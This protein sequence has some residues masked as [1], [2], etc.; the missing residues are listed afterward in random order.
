MTV[1]EKTPYD[2]D[3][4][5][6]AAMA[7]PSVPKV[8]MQPAKPVEIDAA[9]LRRITAG[10]GAMFSIAMLLIT[11]ATVAKA[12]TLSVHGEWA[13]F[14]TAEQGGVVCY[15]GSEPKKAEGDYNKRG[16]TYVLVTH[17][18]S[19]KENDV[20]SVRAGYSY[21]PE[22]QVTVQIGDN[23]ISLFTKDGH[24]W[25][26]DAKSDSELVRA[27]KRGSTMVIRGTSS[28]GTLTTDTYSL[29]G[30][31]AAYNDSRKACGL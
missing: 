10:F 20:V 15:I 3:A 8:T 14:K 2:P 31:T 25:A 18:P 9:Y 13:A 24:A 4:A 5:V 12:E 16:D 28:R 19:L 1:Q 23:T 21:Q 27:M 6:A 26:Y 22:S 29:S 17:R 7:A 11:L 30:F